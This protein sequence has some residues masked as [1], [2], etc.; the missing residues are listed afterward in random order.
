MTA[1]LAFED[2][3]QV[4]H[5]FNALVLYRAASSFEFVHDLC[6]RSLLHIRIHGKL[7]Q[8]MTYRYG[9]REEAG[10][11]EGDSLRHNDIVC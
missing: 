1:H 9:G 8:N 3:V 5:R 10:D 4:T 6:P 11:E 2:R 7:V